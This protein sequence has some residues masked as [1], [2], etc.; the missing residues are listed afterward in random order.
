MIRQRVNRH[1]HLRCLLVNADAIA[2]LP[3]GTLLRV[4]GHMGDPNQRSYFMV[5]V[6]EV[7]A[8]EVMH[9]IVPRGT[10]VEVP[11]E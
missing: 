7:P 2:C 10:V 3:P 1:D 5:E 4:H 11:E 6:V 8:Q 9:I